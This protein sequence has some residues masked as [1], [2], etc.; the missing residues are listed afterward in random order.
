[1]TPRPVADR[2][3][4][5]AGLIVPIGDV[6]WS[7]DLASLADLASVGQ[8]PERAPTYGEVARAGTALV[9]GLAGDGRWT[10]AAVHARHLKRFFAATGMGLGP[11]ATQAFEGLLAASLARDG[12]ELEDFVELVAEMFP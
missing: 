10:E 1:V 11:I 12:D 8:P 7:E 5:L 6:P 3:T 9:A 4:R 2:A